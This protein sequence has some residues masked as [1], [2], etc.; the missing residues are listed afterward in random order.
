MVSE[1]F[2]TNNSYLILFLIIYLFI[3]LDDDEA[4]NNPNLHSKEQDE[5]EI[6]DG[7]SNYFKEK[8]SLF[9][10]LY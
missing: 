7:K 6:P 1:N 10:Y 9:F 2:A 5:L 3:S 8:I 4:Y